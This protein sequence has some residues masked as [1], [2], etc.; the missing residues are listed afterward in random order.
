MPGENGEKDWDGEERCATDAT[1]IAN[2]DVDQRNTRKG[3]K[4]KK[5]ST[6]LAAL[7]SPLL[8]QHTN[9]SIIEIN[10]IYI[11]IYIYV[12]VCVCCRTMTQIVGNQ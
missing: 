6:R 5:Q 1:G 11:Y 8:L 10:S 9:A 12:C 7:S 2:E 4:R 3:R